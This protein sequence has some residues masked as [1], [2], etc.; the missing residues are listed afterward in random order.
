MLLKVLK[1]T[2]RMKKLATQ[3]AWKIKEDNQYSVSNAETLKWR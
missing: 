3:N 2:Q 1:F